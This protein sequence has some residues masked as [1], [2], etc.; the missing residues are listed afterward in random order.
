MKTRLLTTAALILAMAA[1]PPQAKARAMR[2]PAVFL[3]VCAGLI[4]IGI[5]AW[6]GFHMYKMCQK[7]NDPPP[8]K[9]DDQPDPPPPPAPGAN[10]TAPGT[11]NVTATMQLSDTG[12]VLYWDC[13]TNNWADPV[14]GAPVTAI[15]K[16]RLQSTTDWHS[17]QEEVA[18]L[19]YCS[20]SGTTLVFSRGGLP[21]CTNYLSGGT[22]N[23]VQL[24]PAG[25]IAPH[26]FYRLAEP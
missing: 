10:F 6:V 5:G 23:V 17:W 19:G 22:T 26:K 25:M 13:T 1:V 3:E 12:G 15:M 8:P 7:L 11:N 14:S 16:T 4:V 2:K 20:S 18:I 24:D 21:I 9:P